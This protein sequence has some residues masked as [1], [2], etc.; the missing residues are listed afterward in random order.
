MVR[1]AKRDDCVMK[2]KF[3]LLLTD[4]NGG[5]VIIVAA[6]MVFLLG[7]TAMVTDVGSIAYA[8][9]KMVTAADAA[10]LAGAQELVNNSAQA[11]TSALEYASKNGADPE[12]VSVTVSN[13][14]SEITV[15]TSQVVDF[16]FAKVLGFQST[17]VSARAKAAIKPARSVIGIVPFTVPM[18]PPGEDYSYGE[19][20]LLKVGSWKDAPIGSGNFG[21]IALGGTGANNY[22]KNIKHG[23]QGIISVGDY[24][25]TEP[26]N[27][28]GP[29]N[30]GIKYR[31]DHNDTIVIIPLYDSSITDVSGRG[32]IQVAGFACFEIT[33]VE[34]SGNMC[35]VTGKFIKWFL[36]NNA[37]PSLPDDSSYEN[38]FGVYNLMLVE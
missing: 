36:P 38:D 8:R 37:S 12:K 18:P 10:A 14:N 6:A 15:S 16:S 7:L 30:E 29:T 19:E 13:N 27:I 35:N 28:S 22:L 25:D 1:Q 34:G 2:K 9:R 33:G 32:E 4:E 31:L 23:Y 26:G 20:V 5:V 24:I 11:V 17:L 21:A 3:N